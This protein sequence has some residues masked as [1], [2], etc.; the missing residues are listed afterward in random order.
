MGLPSASIFSATCQCDR[1]IARPRRRCF[2]AH[3]RAA[4]AN[5]TEVAMWAQIIT[6]RLKPGKGDELAAVM[7]LLKSA[8]QAGSGLLR[9]TTMRDQQDPHLVYTMVVF[10]SEESARAREQ[11]PRREQA[12]QAVR[13]LM[14]QIFEGPPE[15][16]NLDVVTEST[17]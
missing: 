2:T 6:M 13:E 7:D 5:V 14:G 12:L 9:S 10:D 15:F 11:D 17:F 8:E 3:V 4:G 1:A 16:I